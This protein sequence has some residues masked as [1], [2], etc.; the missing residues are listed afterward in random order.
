MPQQE[1]TL[2]ILQKPNTLTKV[3]DDARPAYTELRSPA[4]AQEL[5]AADKAKSAVERQRLMGDPVWKGHQD[6]VKFY[7]ASKDSYDT[8]V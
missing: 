7:L 3:A 6:T 5:V 8:S 4:R 2:A 1:E